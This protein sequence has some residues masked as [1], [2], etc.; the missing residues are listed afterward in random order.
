MCTGGRGC[1]AGV[2]IGDIGC[3]ANGAGPPNDGGG[4]P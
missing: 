3:A 2:L 1:A 4:A